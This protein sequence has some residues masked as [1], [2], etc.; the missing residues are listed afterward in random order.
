[1]GNRFLKTLMFMVVIFSS[2]FLFNIDKAKAEC[3]CYYQV[4]VA[5]TGLTGNFFIKMSYDTN[6][7]DIVESCD[8]PSEAPANFTCSGGNEKGFARCGTEGCFNVDSG[9]IASQN[10]S[11]SACQSA[12]LYFEV[13]GNG[14]LTTQWTYFN[15]EA[16]DRSTYNDQ[17][18]PAQDSDASDERKPEVSQ[19]EEWGNN[20]SYSNV[21]G[22]PGDPCKTVINNPWLV[23]LLSWLFWFIAIAGLAIFLIMSIMDFIKAVTGS[24]DVNLKN[25]F[26]H[27]LI[28]AIV[29]VILFLL[30]ALLGTIINFLN[31]NF[32]EEGTYEIGSDGNL[33][34][35]IASSE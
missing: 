13:R 32:G 6:K 33:Y 16:I 35:D 20:Y 11:V 29:V 31:D 2:F 3:D 1:M 22:E 34:C 7:A 12:N 15:L 21:E 24:D 25:A 19:I 18:Q 10:C 14:Q 26:K 4:K 23:Q 30:P 17:T 9:Y 5:S 27:L 28:R 8:L